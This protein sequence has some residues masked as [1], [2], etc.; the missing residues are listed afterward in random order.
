MLEKI[1]SAGTAG[2]GGGTF[3]SNVD[4]NMWAR[5]FEPGYLPENHQNQ[6][7]MG[8]LPAGSFSAR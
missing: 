7:K 4:P 2:A 5:L 8:F 6:G 3:I 1:E